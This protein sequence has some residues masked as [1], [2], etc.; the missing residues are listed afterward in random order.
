MKC[1]VL[2]ALLVVAA[3]TRFICPSDLS[4]FQCFETAPGV[5]MCLTDYTW[6]CGNC[7]V[8]WAY[9]EAK[10]DGVNNP[11]IKTSDAVCAGT[12]KPQC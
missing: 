9:C 4:T 12:P 11:P 2:L 10:A 3:N 1:I 5:P 8:K 7:G 6:V